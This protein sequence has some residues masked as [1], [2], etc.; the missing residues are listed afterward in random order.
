MDKRL[1]PPDHVVL[2]L[3]LRWTER[4]FAAPNTARWKPGQLAIL[5]VNHHGQ[6]VQTWLDNVHADGAPADGPPPRFVLQRLGPTVWTLAPSL[7]VP[8][9]LHAYV[10]L[11][12]VPD[13]APWE[14]AARTPDAARDG[15]R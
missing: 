15:A 9:A 13:P 1:L 14:D 5:A 12:D 3:V 7:V 4:A 10:T 11:V 8:G 6:R 2:H